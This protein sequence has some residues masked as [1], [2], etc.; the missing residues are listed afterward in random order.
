MELASQ[1]DLF[2]MPLQL[3][4][5]WSRG[6]V[7]G[8]HQATSRQGVVRVTGVELFAKKGTDDEFPARPDRYIAEVE[9][10]LEIA[11]EG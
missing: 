8:V 1:E 3:L 4:A 6:G 11:S 5:G 2:R 9:E 7:D 10:A